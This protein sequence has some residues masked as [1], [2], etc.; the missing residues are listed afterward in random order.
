MKPQKILI[1]LIAIAILTFPFIQATEPSG[2][3]LKYTYENNL[4]NQGSGGT[5][6]DLVN[7]GATANYS[8][9]KHEGTYSRQYNNGGCE[10]A[11]T[12]LVQYGAC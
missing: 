6:C 2:Y 8:L 1:L 11:W 4:T 12:R 3:F 10:S 7:A 5:N 9:V